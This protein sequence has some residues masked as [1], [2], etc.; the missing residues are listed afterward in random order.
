MYAQASS[1]ENYFD[2]DNF[3]MKENEAYGTAQQRNV[4]VTQPNEAY[5]TAQQRNVV[6]T[7][8]NEAYG[9]LEEDYVTVV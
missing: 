6:V 5:G 4:V 3:G 7:Q 1:A 2:T 8:P 9:T